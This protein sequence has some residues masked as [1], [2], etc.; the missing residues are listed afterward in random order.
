MTHEATELELLRQAVRAAAAELGA[1][2]QAAQASQADHERRLAETQAELGRT[3]ARVTELEE[4][5]AEDALLAHER[6]AAA[7]QAR[8]AAMTELLGSVERAAHWLRDGHA[9]A[10]R[11]HAE[12]EQKARD[13]AL[14]EERLATAERALEAHARQSEA[15]RASL[16]EQRAE[17]WDALET[18]LTERDAALREG[19][20]L[21][22]RVEALADVNAALDAAR[23]ELAS[24]R[25]DLATRLLELTE[26]RNE[27]ATL[28]AGAATHTDLG[29]ELQRAKLALED[30][31]SRLVQPTVPPPPGEAEAALLRMRKPTPVGRMAFSGRPARSATSYSVHGTDLPTEH[32]GPLPPSQAKRKS[33][34]PPR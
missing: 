12:G 34:A 18:A 24:T 1:V 30:L 21:R 4:A 10:L 9:R 16:V 15:E 27:L 6:L 23:E 11:S 5:R 14:L 20:E 19:R 25:A 17:A 32:L 28:R 8:A 13:T 22:G 33:K 31:R 26:A 2:G 29:E 3:R 7:V